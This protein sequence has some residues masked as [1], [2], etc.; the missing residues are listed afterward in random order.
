MPCYYFGNGVVIVCRA[1]ALS[2]GFKKL[3]SS[4]SYFR[5]SYRG[6]PGIS[7]KPKSSPQAQISHT[8]KK[9]RIIIG[10]KH[11]VLKIALV[12]T[13]FVRKI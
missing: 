2:L 13:K 3:L 11:K 10:A 5:D 6:S 8:P 4:L 7:P 12:E 9:I 1:C